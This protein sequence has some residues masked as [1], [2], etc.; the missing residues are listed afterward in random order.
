MFGAG[1]RGGAERTLTDDV[2][3]HPAVR[4]PAGLISLDTDLGTQ[5]TSHVDRSGVVEVQ[6]QRHHVGAVRRRTR[7]GRIVDY[8]DAGDL[9]RGLLQLGDGGGHIVVGGVGPGRCDQCGR[10]GSQLRIMVLECVL[11]VQRLRA[12]HVETA[13]GEVARLGQRQRRRG[14]QRE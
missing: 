10:G 11:D 9:A 13:T 7:L 1:L 2:E 12:G 3:L 6:A 8:L 14:H 4:G 5:L